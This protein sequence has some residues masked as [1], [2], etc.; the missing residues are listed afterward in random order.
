MWTGVHA[1]NTGLWDNTNF[2]W[3]E[4]L[5]SEVPTVG[6]LLREQGYYTAFKGKWHCSEVP[7]SEDA[8][9][10]ELDA[11][12]DR[13]GLPMPDTPANSRALTLRRL[14][15]RRLERLERGRVA[16]LLLDPL[17][18]T[19]RSLDAH[20]WAY[21]RGLRDLQGN[22]VFVLGAFAAFFIFLARRAAT[23]PLQPGSVPGKATP[24]SATSNGL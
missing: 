12:M 17:D 14:I 19:L 23:T 10:D 2:A 22:V 8:L 15:Q 6:H 3:I 4:E 11:Q 16:V 5:S 20:F 18:Q 7:R 1:K 13:A 21:L 24:L 9:L